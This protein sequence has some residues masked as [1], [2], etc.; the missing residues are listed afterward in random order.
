MPSRDTR[1]SQ[2]PRTHTSARAAQTR[3]RPS[4]KRRA[5]CSHK[6]RAQGQARRRERLAA[7]I[8][9]VE[10]RE[11]R[12]ESRKTHAKPRHTH[13]PVCTDEH[14]G[15]RRADARLTI[16][17]PACR[18]QPQ[19]AGARTSEAATAICSV[20]AE[21]RP[22]QRRERG[23]ADTCQAPTHTQVSGHRHTHRQAPRRREADH[24]STCVPRAATR[25]GRKDKR[26]SESGPRSTS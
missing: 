4:L 18:A 1:T 19:G 12:R 22:A 10:H 11:E 8:L 16:P 25:H 26:G 23:P 6:A 5:A 9:N 14:T 13:K 20:Q 21:R 17:P 3:G 15:R 7:Y 2:C 24:P